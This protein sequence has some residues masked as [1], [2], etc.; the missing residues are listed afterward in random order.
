MSWW[1]WLL[2]GLV[3]VLAEVLT[4]GGFALLLF[5]AA[6]LLTGFVAATG[7][8]TA[9]WAQWFLFA[10]LSIALL[11]ALRQPLVRA[12]RPPGVVEDVDTLVGETALAVRE[13]AIDEVGKAELRGTSWSA[14]NVG[15]T[16]LRDGQR[17]RVQKVDGLMLWVKAE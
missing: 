4:P 6:A 7:V 1:I 9:W 17:C 12:L 14:R 5:G 16:P 2:L 8:L 15:L 13:I 10:L 3:L 11:L